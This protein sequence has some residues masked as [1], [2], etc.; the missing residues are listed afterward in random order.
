MLI[1]IDAGNTNITVGLFKDKKGDFT[2]EYS[3]R[4]N[5][6]PNSTA[7]EIAVHI[8]SHIIFNKIDPESI[9]Y[10]IV[11]SVVPEIDSVLKKMFLKTFFIEEPIFVNHILDTGL[12]Y[13]Y[14][15]PEEI[16][17]DRIVNAV[18]GNV[19]YGGPLIIIDFG[20]ATT[21]CCV[22]DNGEYMGGQILPGVGLSLNAL[23]G[24]AA[25]LSAVKIEKPGSPIG[26]STEQS[27]QAGIFYQTIG[28]I[29]KITSLLKEGTGA[30]TKVLATG[31]LSV[32]FSDLSCIDIIDF[33][34]TL[35]GLK[36]IHDRNR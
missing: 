31:G 9:K 36:I 21:F 13:T 34:L 28:S 26:K 33:D 5:T 14:P 23:T 32:L 12:K 25:K 27:I 2:P 35:K 1:G 15:V 29:E 20:T 24:K 22:S 16:G 30:G 3:W 4:F 7:D 17:A 8:I 19:L 10:A 18:A 11:S 6:M